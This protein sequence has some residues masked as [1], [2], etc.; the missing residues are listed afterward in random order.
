MIGYCFSYGIEYNYT[1]YFNH[2]IERNAMYNCATCNTEFMKNSTRNTC[3]LKCTILYTIQKNENGCWIWTGSTS[4]GTYGKLRY[5]QKTIS[6]HRASYEAFK[7]EIK[8]GL[9]VCHTCD[10]KLCVNPDHLFLGTQ[11]ENIKDASN[12]KRMSLGKNNVF[13]IYDD[14]Q[15]QAM[16]DMKAIGYSYRK[17]AKMFNCSFV[18]V[19]NLIKNKYRK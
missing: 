3:S 1:K 4:M 12:K 18:H 17:I 10:I 11:K 7:G 6:A 15:T 2:F 5:K 14:E 8:N 9:L 16:R 19:Y 13:T